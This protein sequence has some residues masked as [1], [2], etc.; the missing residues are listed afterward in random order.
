MTIDGQS[1][2]AVGFRGITPYLHYENAATMLDWLAR[3]FGFEERSRY[4]DAEGVVREAEMFAGDSEIWM[5]GRDPG[6]WVEHGGGPDQLILVWVDDVDAQHARVVAAGVDADEPVDQP[7]GVRSFNVTDPQGYQW[8]F[9]RRIDAGYQAG[10]GGLE[11][12]L[13]D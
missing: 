1:S 10:A 6:Y 12:I 7:Y 9:M 3:V 2:Q 8:G 13:P 5:A 4:V 11:E